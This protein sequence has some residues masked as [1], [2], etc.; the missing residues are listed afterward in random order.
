VDL[1]EMHELGRTLSTSVRRLLDYVW[2]FVMGRQSIPAD[3]VEAQRTVRGANR[4]IIDLLRD[5]DRRGKLSETQRAVQPVR[6]VL[7]TAGEPDGAYERLYAL[8]LPLIIAGHETT[9]HTLSWAFYEMARN[10]EIERAVLAEILSFRAAH[11][12]RPLTTAEYDE[13]PLAW[14]LLAETL[15]RHSPV[16]S[17]PRTTRRE[18]VV[19]PDP[20]TG[21][22]GFRYPSGAMIVFSMG[23]IHFDPRRWSD[24]AAFRLERWLDGVRD[25]M[26]LTEKGRT[27]RATIRAREQALDSVTFSDGPARCPGQHFNAHEFVLVLDALL[28]RY[29]FELAHPDQEV[30]HSETMV[31]GPEQGRM[32]VRIRP[33]LPSQS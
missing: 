8:I 3:Y 23:G 24:P 10:A 17:T 27:V 4:A 28:P 6:M 9:G 33:R 25:G 19:P 11:G 29:R 32:A 7:E 12:G 22:G 30:P 18:G 31:V 14:A 16:Q 21:I 5:L 15:R 13:R 20:Q 2:E 26:S 1:V